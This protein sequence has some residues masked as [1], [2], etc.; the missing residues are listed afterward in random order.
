MEITTLEQYEEFEAWLEATT[1]SKETPKEE[2]D[3]LFE[4]LQ[5][6][7]KYERE[8]LKTSIDPRPAG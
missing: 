3:K 8:T 7:E 2:W 1:F 5:A 4:V 6:V